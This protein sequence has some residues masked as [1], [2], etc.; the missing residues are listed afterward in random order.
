[1]SIDRYVY[2]GPFVKCR[3]LATKT[4]ETY[5][6]CP[7]C[8][9]RIVSGHAF[10]GRHGK[11][12]DRTVEKEDTTADQIRNMVHIA[13]ILMPLEYC[14]EPVIEGYICLGIN[15][16]QLAGERTRLFD[17]RDPDVYVHVMPHSVQD[18]ELDEFITEFE[19]DIDALRPLCEGI[20]HHW[21]LVFTAT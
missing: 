3:P 6:F 2:L 16:T 1:M 20:T 9:S 15:K 8:N 19:A 18:A 10:C 12:E 11:G 4:T 14:G 21:G 13:D 17:V 7:D 5:R